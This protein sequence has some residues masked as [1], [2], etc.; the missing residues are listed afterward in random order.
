MPLNNEYRQFDGGHGG[1]AGHLT[2]KGCE[3]WA[4]NILPLVKRV[5]AEKK[6]N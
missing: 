1:G 6:V 5:I 3:Q 2:A 4:K